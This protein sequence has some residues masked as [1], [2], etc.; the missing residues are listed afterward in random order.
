MR[1]HEPGRTASTAKTKPRQ[2]ARRNPINKIKKKLLSRTV[3]CRQRGRIRRL[4]CTCQV[5][6]QWVSTVWVWLCKAQQYGGNLRVARLSCAVSDDRER[7]HGIVLAN[8]V[9]PVLGA[10][11]MPPSTLLCRVVYLIVFLV[12]ALSY[13]VPIR[14]LIAKNAV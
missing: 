10:L 5:G 7:R 4:T 3:T 6:S 2:L 14:S 12:I 9:I 11:R 8:G 1:R 13:V